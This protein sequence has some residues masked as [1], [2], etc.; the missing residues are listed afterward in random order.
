MATANTNSWINYIATALVR[1]AKTA[2]GTKTFK[3]VSVPVDKAISDDGFLSI[4]ANNATVYASKT[5]TGEVSTKFVNILLGKPDAV[6]KAS[7]KKNG[8]YEKIEITNAAIV[9]A[10]QASR[11]AYKAAH[12]APAVETETEVDM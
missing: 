10:Y 8:A 3:S 4:T 6:K 5:K 2:D 11:A 1:D 9:D 12:A 7:V